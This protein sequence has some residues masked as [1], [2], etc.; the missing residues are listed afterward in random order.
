[1]VCAVCL[2]MFLS[3]ERSK[4]SFLN[5]NCEL[6]SIINVE[7]GKSKFPC[8]VIIQ[9]D[10]RSSV[11]TDEDIGSCQHSLINTVLS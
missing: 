5:V 11:L 3:F 4:H 2:S 10:R 6:H 1:M 9:I 7:S 8:C